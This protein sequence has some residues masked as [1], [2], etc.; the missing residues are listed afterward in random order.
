MHG[1]QSLASVRACLERRIVKVQLFS[2][3]RA[4]ADHLIWLQHFTHPSSVHSLQQD[5]TSSNSPFCPDEYR[6]PLAYKG[7]VRSNLSVVFQRNPSLTYS[8]SGDCKNCSIRINPPTTAILRLSHLL[9]ATACLSNCKAGRKPPP[10]SNTKDQWRCQEIEGR[11]PES[12]RAE[13]GK[14]CD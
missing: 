5:C 1:V 12:S 6:P 9:A 2:V 10:N 14:H 11:Y 8:N 4:Q 3:I 7:M 13:G